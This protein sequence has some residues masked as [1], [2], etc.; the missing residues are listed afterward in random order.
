[1]SY[2]FS[3]TVK[4]KETSSTGT[5]SKETNYHFHVDTA[6]NASDLITQTAKNAK[7]MSATVKKVEVIE[8]NQYA[9]E[10]PYRNLSDSEILELLLTK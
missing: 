5:I 4:Y 1:M 3:I 7:E 2:G 6:T 8:E 9:S 10:N